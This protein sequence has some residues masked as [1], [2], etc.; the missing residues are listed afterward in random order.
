LNSLINLFGIANDGCSI[1]HLSQPPWDQDNNA[2]IDHT[3]RNTQI[4]TVH[5]TCQARET[6]LYAAHKNDNCGYRNQRATESS[7][8]AELGR[9]HYG[10]H[11][12][13]NEVRTV[14]IT[15]NTYKNSLEAGTFRFCVLWGWLGRGDG[16]CGNAREQVA[17][18]ASA[19]RIAK[20]FVVTVTATS[21]CTR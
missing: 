5:N 12:C 8:A 13:R 9:H 6:K 7:M 11:S 1:R 2:A 21:N 18:N 19:K 4:D 20:L 10:G 15:Y 17:S 16:Q 14:K 3:W